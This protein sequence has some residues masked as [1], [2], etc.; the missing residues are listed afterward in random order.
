MSQKLTIAIIGC[1][2]FAKNFV[3]LFKHHPNV[4]KVYVCDL[5]KSREADFSARFGVETI[6]TFEDALKRPDIN[7]IGNFTR[8]HTHGD[9]TIRALQAGKHVYSA[10]PMASTIEECQKIVELVKATG[11]TYF[12]GETCY[13]YPCSMYCREAYKAG[14]FG[15]FSYGAS[16]YYHHINEISYGAVAQERVQSTR[17][18]CKH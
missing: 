9:I 17:Q 12:I 10:V 2:A 16:Q 13:Y 1:G 5:I 8:R 14:I 6:A 3:N 15:K 7:C 11:L 4:E 18:M